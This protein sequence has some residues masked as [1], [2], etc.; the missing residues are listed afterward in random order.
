MSDSLPVK[1]TVTHRFKDSAQRVFDAWTHPVRASCWLFVAAPER[2]LVR[3]EINARVGGR[4]CLSD[5]RDGEAVEHVGEYLE[6]ERPRRLVFTFAVP[7]YSEAYDRVT[8]DIVPDGEDCVL[9]LT[10]EMGPDG[11]K[12]KDSTQKGWSK[13]LAALDSW[14]YEAPATIQSR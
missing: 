3:A 10:H 11:E 7:K 9:T 13:M 2:S 14:L 5:L 12:W 1:L 8:V 6:V 4:F